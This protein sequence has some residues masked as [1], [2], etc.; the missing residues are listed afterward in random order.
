MKQQL[1][2]EAGSPAL[3][4]KHNIV[5]DVDHTCQAKADERKINN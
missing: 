2:E 5:C 3:R 4:K 1:L